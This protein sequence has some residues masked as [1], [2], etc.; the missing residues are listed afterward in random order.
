[1][2]TDEQAAKLWCPMG[3]TYRSL[4]TGNTTINEPADITCIGQMCAMWRWAGWVNLLEDG[5][6]E[7]DTEKHGPHVMPMGPTKC[8]HGCVRVGYCGL[9]GRPI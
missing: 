1:M 2:H 4:R 6:M 7:P 5:S 8:Q 9:A 3:R